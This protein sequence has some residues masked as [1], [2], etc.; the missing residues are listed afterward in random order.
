MDYEILAS[1]L[2][3]AAMVIVWAV[4]PHGIEEPK[5]AASPAV[6]PAS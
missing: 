2:V 4:A 6:T 3:F 1:I 5:T